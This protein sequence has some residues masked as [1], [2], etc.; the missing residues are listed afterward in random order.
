MKAMAGTVLLVLLASARAAE[1]APAAAPAAA[2]PALGVYRWGAANRNGG[3]GANEAYAQW[4]GRPMVWAEDFEPTE[5]WDNNIDGGSWQ[6]GEWSAWKKAVAGRKLILSVPLLPGGWDRSGPKRGLEAGKRVSFAAGARGDYNA[7]FQRLAEHL[8]HFGLADSILRLGW[9]FNGGWYTWRASGEAADFAGYWRQIVGAMRAVKGAEELRFCFNPALGWLQFP[10]E[11]AWPGDESVD[12]VG[13]DV[14]DESWAKDTY[15]LPADASAADTAARRER[16]WNEVLY[17]GNHGLAFWRDFALRHGKPFSVP[18]WGV[19]KRA[20][21]HG[22]LDN[23]G[24]IE[25]MHAFLVDPANKV[26]FHSYFDVQAGDGHHQLSPGKSGAE[27]SDFPLS[28]ARFKALF[29]S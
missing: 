26:A 9:E 4:L 5:Q 15:P 8:V 27:K 17:N 2:A 24:F 16:A 28:A 7:H 21:G 22:G 10:A 18:E 3:A 25:H 14:Y 20:D 13:L 6:L 11:Q 29:G 19:S 23:P 1:E 12:Y